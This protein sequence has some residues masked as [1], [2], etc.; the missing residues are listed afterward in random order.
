MDRVEAESC[1][2]AQLHA[3]LHQ[4]ADI[5]TAFDVVRQASRVIGPGYRQLKA[6]QQQIAHYTIAVSIKEE[7][8][9]NLRRLKTLQFRATRDPTVRPHTFTIDGELKRKG[10]SY[11]TTIVA[12][13]H[14]CV[15]RYMVVEDTSSDDWIR[16][17]P[18]YQ[19]FLEAYGLQ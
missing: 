11:T 1:L 17:S 13:T 4:Q 14:D 6:K 10:I 5:R 2:N 16:S 7:L 18:T 9:K 8:Q 15:V 3:V 12:S 19:Q